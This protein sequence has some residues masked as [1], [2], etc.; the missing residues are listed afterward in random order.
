MQETSP[1]A[2]IEC[3]VFD[4]VA[5]EKKRYYL[6]FDCE[7]QT[8]SSSAAG[9]NKIEASLRSFDLFLPGE[10][11]IPVL[12]SAEISFD[13][14]EIYIGENATASLKL[15]FDDGQVYTE[16]YTAVYESL[17][18]SVATV[19]ANGVVTG[20]S[21]GKAKIKVTV[22][23]EY[24]DAVSGEG[25]INIVKKV[26]LTAKSYKFG[27]GAYGATADIP[28]KTD[29]AK[30][31]AEIGGEGY[32]E[33]TISIA[34]FAKDKKFAQTDTAPWLF[35]G[36]KY[37]LDTNLYAGSLWIQSY[38]T[39]V[40]LSTHGFMMLLDVTQKGEYT[41]VLEYQAL[42]NG[43]VNDV[44]LIPA[45][46]ARFTGK[47]FGFWR[48]DNQVF[49]GTGDVSI[50]LSKLSDADR[51]KYRLGTVDMQEVNP[52]NT[53]EYKVFPNVTLE[54]KKYYLIFDTVEQ[55]VNSDTDL[56]AGNK[57]E[58][59][60]RS[61]NLELPG[62]VQVPVLS[63]VEMTFDKQ[64]LPLTRNAK[65]AL[66]MKYDDGDSFVEDCE[67]KYEALNDC[68]SIDNEGNITALKVGTAKFKVTVTPGYGSPVSSEAEL[69]IT[70][71]PVLDSLRFSE[72][73]ISLLA[74]DV[75]R[76]K[77]E[78]KISA[79][80]SDSEE[81]NADN[82]DITYESSDTT[83]AEVSDSGVIS[84][85]SE[86]KAIISATVISEEG[87]PCKGEISVIV[88][89]DMPGITV[90]FSK[91]VAKPDKSLPDITPG[92]K[93]LAN[94]GT[95]GEFSLG[96]VTDTGLS[97]F[98][99]NT[100]TTKYWP[101][102]TR[103]Q[104]TFAIS[105][106]ADIEGWYKT[107]LIGA[108]H[109]QGA[110]Y[111]IYTE[112]DY[113]GDRSFW[114][115]A[116]SD[117][118]KVP[119]T[120]DETALNTVYLRR[121]E[122]KIYIRI[123]KAGTGNPY[124]I[125]NTL[126][127]IP[128]PGDVTLS[129]VEA[130]FPDELAVGETFE[131]EA[132]AFMS[133][134]T[135]RHF[136][137][138][139]NDG[140]E[141]KVRVMEAFS[142]N[143]G[144]TVSGLD[145]VMGKTG[146]REYVIT[147]KSAGTTKVEIIAKL[148]DNNFAKATKEITIT[149]DLLTS[150]SL[151]MAAEELFAGDM[152]YLTVHPELGGKR[153]SYSSAIES[154]ITSSDE[155]VVKV[156][157]NVLYAISEGKATLTVKS[158]FNGKS[159][160]NSEFTV[161]VLPE[162]MTDIR[163]TSGG[164]EVIR[165]TANTDETI[166]MFVTAIS[167]LGNELPMENASV[168]VTALTPDIA[169]I[170]DGE[171]ILP[172]SEGKAKFLVRIELDGRIREKEVTL[173]VALGKSKATYMTAE[174]AA[175]ARENI[176][177]YSWAKDE[178]D[179]YKLLADRYLNELDVL[180]DMIHS[181]GIPRGATVGYGADPDIY[182][183]RY[184]NVDLRSEYGSYAW[185]HDALR[186][187]WKIQCPDCKNLFPTNDFGSFYKLGL[188][189]YGEF[190]RE[191]ALEEHAKLFGDPN[192]EVGSD[193]YYGYGKGYLKNNLYDNLENVSTINGGK[194]L[195]PGETTETWGVDDGFGYVPKMPDGTP[196]SYNDGKDIERHSYIAEYLHWGVWRN[197]V[198][199]DA[200]EDCA[201]AYFYTGDKKYGRISAILLD[202]LADFY[203][204]YDIMPYFTMVGNSHG[205]AGQ[206]KI[207]G[208][209]WETG[210]ITKYIVAYDMV[211]DMYDDPY[212]LDY[213]SKK[214]ETWRMRHSKENASQIRTNVE[215]GILR[216]A[217]EGIKSD[218][219]SGNFGM[220]QKTNAYAAVVLDDST[221]SLE[222]IDFLM[223]TGW[224]TNPKTGGGIFSQLL[225]EVDADGQGNE[226]S[227]YNVYWLDNLRGVNEAFEGSRFED[228]SFN[229]NPKYMKM[230]Y[231]NIPLIAGT[232][233]P[234]IGDTGGTADTAHWANI[235]EA[236]KGW[237]I[238][239][240]PIFAQVLYLLNG[241][242]AKGLRYGTTDNN[243]ERL[244][245]E[246][247]AVIDEYGVLNLKSDVMTNFGFAIL[248]DGADFTDSTVPTADDTRRNAWMYFGSNSGHG[249]SDTLSLG[250]TAF[251]LN[252]LPDLG[253][254]EQTGTQPNRL[255]WVST[256]LAHNTAT[257]NGKEQITNEEVRGKVQH[258]DSTESVQVMDV[259]APYVYDEVSEY[260]RSVVTVRVDDKNSYTVDFFRILGGEEHL[261]SL[262]AQ[263]NEISETIGL[264][265]TLVEDEQGNYISGS[266]LDENGEY[267]GTMAG[268][269]ATYIKDTVTGK[270][271][272]PDAD[273]PLGANEVE[274][275]VEYGPDPYSPA[276]WTYNTLYPRGYTWL[277]NVDR[278]TAPEN[279][280][281]I[282]FAIKDFNRAISDGK[283]LYL[284]TTLL[285]DSNI[286]S[287]ADSEIAIAD[288]LPP[289]KAEN[290]AIDK[291]KY[292]LVKNTGNNLDTVFTTVF[293][294]YRKNRYIES[295]DELE[296]SISDGS[297][298]DGD[299]VR[300]VKI[301]HVNGRCDYV[302]WATNNTVTYNVTTEN[303]ELS[304]RGFVGVYTVNADGENIY[305]YV[306]DG[307]IL[308]EPTGEKSA[309]TGEVISFTR[310]LA[311]ENEIVIKPDAPIS[312]TE[313]ET[314]PGRLL[315]IENGDRQRSGS[316]EIIS[317]KADGD[318]ITLSVG[319]VTT[320][321][322][323]KNSMDFS[324]GYEYMIEEGQRARIAISYSDDFAPVFDA[325]S[326]G[327]TSA[328]SAVKVDVN[329]ESP[330]GKDIIYTAE[331]LPGGASLDETTGEI[332]WN[333]RRSQIGKNHL[334][335]TAID[336]DGR[337]STIH[338]YITV[339]GST[340]GDNSDSSTPS[341]STPPTTADGN[342]K[343]DNK[344][345]TTTP[346]TPETETEGEAEN[347]R[348]VDLDAHAWAAD[349]I[350]ALADEG[351]IRGTSETTF[352]PTLNITRA[353]FA[354]LL[355][356]AFK[357]TS[358]NEE[359]FADVEASDYFAK[360]LAIARNTGIV[361]GIGDNKFAPRN[362]ITRQDMMTIV[363]RALQ[364]LEI[365]LE[366]GD[367]EYSDFDSVAE[368]AK[369]AV[370]ALIVSGLVNGKSGK[371]SPTDYTTRAEVAV[372]IKRILDYMK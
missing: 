38:R 120:S 206:G 348:F 340:T 267:K 91:T 272:L 324:Q 102:D 154:E 353:D 48:L 87:K 297:E 8:V 156:E 246:V 11:D 105:V 83:V 147:G 6:I 244:E 347:V 185:V 182:K 50:V 70:E 172:I 88:Y 124:A 80:M 200:I 113:L 138:L 99:A 245:R 210:L 93:I 135:V 85:V 177:K 227:S 357:L 317:A 264:D 119:S 223:A 31:T 174:K 208:S 95:V 32:A 316:Y 21:E 149:N 110:F 168:S 282:E 259:S 247:Q 198:V 12:G 41:P 231:A 17:N 145:Y 132:V 269:D 283:N 369:D 304:F 215:D 69:E 251:G 350:N 4:K 327:T 296:V 329:A 90:D 167:N 112:E 103:K 26:P 274:L 221:Q 351:V 179:R 34:R 290:K 202:R 309:I 361:N 321:R 137:D 144:A 194:G 364:A 60:L 289:Q 261:Y 262:H 240:D 305:N 98:Y 222:W 130:T 173:R 84:A 228:K 121:G 258:F 295:A 148:S 252:L 161:E 66:L 49:E 180:Y 285:N 29:F 100:Y 89:A 239:G 371:I 123:R 284:H 276:A 33:D 330:L 133:D 315:V 52:D 169:D 286:E 352:S 204:D 336:S 184:C 342:E 370:K 341:P 142:D 94:E 118:T 30:D 78:T 178:A 104:T 122:N 165:L 311:F 74:G 326:D 291:L 117:E 160:E 68:A 313:L 310:E 280:V 328:G 35:E 20:I 57:I 192:A 42:K 43:Y 1:D 334:A 189:E 40:T 195:R 56:G 134:G 268:R 24:G 166:P 306:L 218:A 186:N 288:G 131:G 250:L 193:A 242:T 47:S 176:K 129:R 23:P 238:T 292:V 72:D 207:I 58:L 79:V 360:E 300:A 298:K 152:T 27:Y 201:Y 62:E 354:L 281:E 256:T 253:Y 150:T 224:D 190:S 143:D 157:G 101:A 265:F 159:V 5:L 16:K 257:V 325:V 220:E 344:E 36:M 67:I 153:I 216:A 109:K 323:L 97:F 13:N 225:D 71:K 230:Y 232:Y 277:K 164:S 183:C 10:V 273:I 372:L 51:E 301:A 217:F 116:G 82:L 270:V 226:A 136:G 266:Q 175:N 275:P 211:Y 139:A 346:S 335:V 14:T 365:E 345:E 349:A 363:Y 356:R 243:P 339:Y 197:G 213:I 303:G 203:P 73:S 254:P 263:S 260:R 331:M 229:N 18:P 63:E 312:A 214:N 127:F 249:H 3:K 81:E 45:D 64:S 146:K 294:P 59:S 7:G 287:G 320:I 37:V 314:L 19:D 53:S 318:N 86:G 155:N 362:T 187:P 199:G 75:L 299:A 278:D 308:G 107:E 128:V 44:L 2:N 170:V 343:D 337:K 61:F 65:A 234:Q 77:Y 171:R 368:Y 233:S 236:T 76:G 367:V 106:N 209:I 108:L 255:Q 322:K 271:R 196:Y 55:K 279:K 181:E 25:E 141:E 205:G 22:T 235:D 332:T 125:V 126:R 163:A 111:S 158:T 115:G 39:R 96:T 293:E 212:V 307:D 319:D 15:K 219:V 191:R 302:F 248:R 188:N 151:T 237:Q 114:N 140:S 9:S 358:E 366:T 46:D 359:N 54:K 338:F 28:A 355:V 241:N 333:P 92:Y 162:G